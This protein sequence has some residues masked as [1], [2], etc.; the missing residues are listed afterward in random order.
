VLARV[1]LAQGHPEQALARLER[2][3]D[4]ATAQQRTGSVIELRALQALAQAAIG[5]DADAV[6]T[7]AAALLLACP[8]G[9][10][11]VFTDEGAAMAR[12]LRRLIAAQSSDATAA[13]DVP[14]D[15][16]A[17]LQES[18]T[19][20]PAPGRVDRVD[21]GHGLVDPLTDRELEVLQLVATGSRN[22]D[23][24]EQLVVTLDTVKKHVSHILDKLGATNRTEA[25]A[26]AR[27]LGLIPST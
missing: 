17:R 8:R 18:F 2:L 27:K 12:L 3:L 6:S 19:T 4:A 20:T 10:V 5:D 13:S 11:R 9:Y 24:A 21:A 22:A 23:V 7:I 15:C 16:L 1:R 25:V 26:R 14:F